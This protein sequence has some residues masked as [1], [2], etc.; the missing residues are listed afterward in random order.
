[1]VFEPKSNDAGKRMSFSVSSRD[2]GRSRRDRSLLA[3]WLALE[4]ADADAKLC[5]R[6]LK[7]DIRD[8]AVAGEQRNIVAGRPG[9]KQQLSF[10][11]R[12]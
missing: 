2:L 12:Q 8:E 6:C 4:A 11:Q 10:L 7:R 3:V 5:S 1:M 9:R